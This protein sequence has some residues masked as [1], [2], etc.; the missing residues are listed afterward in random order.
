MPAPA[1]DKAYRNANC[2]RVCS[3][4][5]LFYD[6]NVGMLCIASGQRVEPIRTF[7]FIGVIYLVIFVVRLLFVILANSF[8]ERLEKVASIVPIS[9]TTSMPNINNRNLQQQP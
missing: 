1:P 4:L 7:V 3:I 6:V 5:F 9:T 8:I 2:W